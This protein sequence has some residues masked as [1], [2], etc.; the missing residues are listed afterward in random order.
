MGCIKKSAAIGWAPMQQ[1]FPYS[2][3]YDDELKTNKKPREYY[4]GGFQNAVPAGARTATKKNHSKFVISAYL[5]IQ[6][7]IVSSCTSHG[8]DYGHD[9]HNVFRSVGL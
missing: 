7:Y 1:L 5:L 6:Q 9:L 4:L 2:F 8:G 3:L